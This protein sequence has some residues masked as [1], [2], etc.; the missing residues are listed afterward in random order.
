MVMKETIIEKIA[1]TG[2]EKIYLHESDSNGNRFY[3]KYSSIIGPSSPNWSLNGNTNG[4]LASI[5][6]LD[7]YDLPIVLGG[8][9][10]I[11]LGH[12]DSYNG[13]GTATTGAPRIKIGTGTFTNDDSAILINRSISGNNLFSHSIRDESTFQSGPTTGA[14]ASFDASP[15]INGTTRLNHVNG[16]Q[17]RLIFNNSG[18]ADALYGHTSLFVN[19]G[20]NVTNGYGYHAATL[21]G[22][23]TYTNY[24]GYFMEP[25]T[26]PNAY[27]LYSAGS[28]PSYI[29]GFLQTSGDIQ[30]TGNIISNNIWSRDDFNSVGLGIGARTSATSGFF[31]TL[32]GHNAGTNSTTAT[33]LFNTFIGAS[34]GFTNTTGSRNT[35]LGA[36][37]GYLSTGSDNVFI[38]KDAGYNE[39]GSNKLY[40]SNSNTSTPLIGGDFLTQ[41][42]K[43]GGVQQFS[44]QFASSGVGVS[45]G[46]MFYGTDGALYFKGGSGTVTLIAAN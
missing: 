25:Q 36:Y 18:G 19:N 26:N 41:E 37:S 10:K 34:T 4:A 43:I 33:T 11:R 42:L 21:E 28:S 6:T 24:F 9:E 2:N 12:S 5:G 40:I 7:N 46:S 35:Y 17:T 20:G 23:G 30:T 27:F 45:N 13:T 39:L 16:H 29:G 1:L 22:S 31:Q 15:T 14:Y 3:I 44:V 8:V 38:G 32:V